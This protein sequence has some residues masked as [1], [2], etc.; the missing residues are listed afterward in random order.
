MAT[1]VESGSD[2]VDDTLNDPAEVNTRFD[3]LE[4]SVED[5]FAVATGHD[6]DGVNS[7]FIAGDN[8]EGIDAIQST[9]SSFAVG[10]L[11]YIT[12]KSGVNYTVAKAQAKDPS[13]TSLYAQYVVTVALVTAVAGKAYKRARVTGQ[14]TT[15][16]TIGRPL[17]LSGTA[18]EFSIGLPAAATGTQVVGFVEAVSAT[19]GVINF[20]IKGPIP[21]SLADQV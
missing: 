20:D 11:V 5:A 17:W 3:T 7:A 9:G 19:V 1:T 13:N 14:V 15:G 21:H 16:G 12:G 2:L 18:G 10:T 6:H 4:T 8:G